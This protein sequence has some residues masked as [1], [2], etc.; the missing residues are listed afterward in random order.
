MSGAEVQADDVLVDARVRGVWWKE[1][2]LLVDDDGVTW[3]GR[4][5]PFDEITAVSYWSTHGALEVGCEFRLHTAGT[6][7]HIGFRAS[8]DEQYAVFTSAIGALRTHVEPRLV[9]EML[10]VLDAGQDVTV[11]SLRLNRAGFGRGKPPVPWEA[12]VAI[13]PPAV[14]P[15]RKAIIGDMLVF[16]RNDGGEVVRIADIFYERPNGPVLPALISACVARYGRR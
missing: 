7:T 12:I 4:H 10:G 9:H 8:N 16:A 1:Q 3:R 11:T 2:R 5:I 13:R 6:K 15:P 14:R